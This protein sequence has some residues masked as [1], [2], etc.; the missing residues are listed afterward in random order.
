MIE[1]LR[2]MPNYYLQYF[3]QTNKKLLCREASKANTPVNREKGPGHRLTV[4]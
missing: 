3:Y 4:C 2:M 1:I